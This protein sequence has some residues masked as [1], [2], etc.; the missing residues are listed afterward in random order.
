[1]AKKIYLYIKIRIGVSIILRIWRNMKYNNINS[2]KIG[3]SYG[4]FKKDDKKFLKNDPKSA[5]KWIKE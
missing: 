2:E 3:S 1:M 4:H 5:V